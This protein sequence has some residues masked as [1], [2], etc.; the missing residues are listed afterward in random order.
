MSLIDKAKQ[1]RNSIIADMSEVTKEHLPE[2]E[3][4]KGGDGLG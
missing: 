1:M 4:I 2:Q 3:K